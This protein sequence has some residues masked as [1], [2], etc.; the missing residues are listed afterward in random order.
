VSE[1]A[2]QAAPSTETA[3]VP[4]VGVRSP[5]PEPRVARRSPPES[6]IRRAAIGTELGEGRAL[7][8]QLA[9]IDVAAPPRPAPRTTW[10]RTTTTVIQPASSA[11]AGVEERTP[12]IQTIRQ[13]PDEDPAGEPAAAEEAGVATEQPLEEG[14]VAPTEAVAA[15]SLDTV[16]STIAHVPSVSEA[17]AGPS[18]FGVTRSDVKMSNA[19]VTHAGTVFSLSADFVHTITWKVRSG[20]G[21]ASQKDISGETDS[22]ITSTNYPT[23]VSDLTPNTSDLMGRPP[24]TKFWAEDLTKTH[25]LFHTTQRSG[26]YGNAAA[27]AIKTSLDAKT[28]ATEAGVKALLPAALNDGVTAMNALI[29]ATS[30]ESDAYKDGAPLYTA[31]ADAIKKRGDKGLY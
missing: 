11:D 1:R 17:G 6:P 8:H 26:T 21:P 18:G 19:V 12:F 29:T 30:T 14:E 24:R 4:A 22:D 23:V 13:S 9:A 15:S 3:P 16:S 28:A 31:R 25:E 27:A 10:G 5:A 7:R 20:T 2:A